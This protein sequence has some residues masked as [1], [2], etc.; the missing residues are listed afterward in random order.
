VLLLSFEGDGSDADLIPSTVAGFSDGKL[1]ATAR[2]TCSRV[3][4]DESGVGLIGT[5]AL[6][7]D[8]VGPH[9]NFRGVA[10]TRAALGRESSRRYTSVIQ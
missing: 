10:E 7:D 9:R 5:W 8:L 1:W 6:L 3:V 2:S 4:V